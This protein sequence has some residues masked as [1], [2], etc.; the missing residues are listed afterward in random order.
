MQL[1]TVCSDLVAAV[2]GMQKQLR[3]FMP[4]VCAG[5]IFQQLHCMLGGSNGTGVQCTMLPVH[6]LSSVGAVSGAFCGRVAVRSSTTGSD[7]NTRSKCL[8]VYVV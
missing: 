5:V 1:F 6:V 4:Y 7:D 3:L 2:G 8:R